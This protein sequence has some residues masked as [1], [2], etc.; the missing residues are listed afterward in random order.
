MNVMTNGSFLM[1]LV[2]AG[3]EIPKARSGAQKLR[4]RV[5]IFSSVPLPA[6]RSLAFD[7]GLPAVTSGREWSLGND[8]SCLRFR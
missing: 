7:C 8:G 6:L 4:E 2:T 3:H 5:G 1:I